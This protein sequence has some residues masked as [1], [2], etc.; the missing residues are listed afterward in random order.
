VAAQ[1][2]ATRLEDLQL[3]E[4]YTAPAFAAFLERARARPDL[5]LLFWNT[6]GRPAPGE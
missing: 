4:V 1:A 2:T 6:C 5:R 3:D